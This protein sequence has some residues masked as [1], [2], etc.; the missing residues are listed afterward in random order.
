MSSENKPYIGGQA[1]LEG[2]MMRAP[3]SFAIVVRRKDGSLQLRERTISDPRKGWG[4]VPF[5]RGLVSL[6][7]SLKIGNEALRFSSKFFE[8][9]YAAANP[10]LSALAITTMSLGSEPD[11]TAAAMK[12]AGGS[13]DEKPKGSSL[14]MALIMVFVFIMLPQ[15]VAGGVNKMFGLGLEVQSPAYQALTGAFKLCIVVGYMMALRNVKEIRRVFQFHG[16][17]HKAI[18]CYEAG[19]DLTVANAKKKTTLHARCG[20]TFLVMVALVSVIVF[21]A[22]GGLLP[23]IQTGNAVL[24]NVVFF[25]EKLPFVPVI[26]AC[27]FELQRIFA[28]FFTKGPLQIVLWPGFM[29]QK[30]TTIEPDDDQLEVALASLK[31]TLFRETGKATGESVDL[32]VASYEELLGRESLGQPQ[33][34]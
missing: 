20:T 32:K 34:A 4:K 22:V 8:E 25:F 26:T 16:A 24:D 3:T 17:E 21:T 27:T 1:V 23:K 28:R 13:K 33:P 6:V 15:G 29:V 2:V 18:S 11:G 14:L 31:M 12:E 10:A 9:D 19:E 7:E 5:V 30:I